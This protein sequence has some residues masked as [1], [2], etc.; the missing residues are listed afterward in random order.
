MEIWFDPQTAGKIG[1]LI[2]TVLGLTGALIGCSCGIC[3]RKGYRKLVYA[4]F[5]SAIAVSILLLITGVI[6]LCMKQPYHVWYVF[7]WSG[8]IGTAVF[9]GLLPVMRRRFIQSE[10]RKMQGE[11]L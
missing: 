4:I 3:V 11:D 9:G 7:V 1:G 10:M 6:A 8:V 2:G 5:I